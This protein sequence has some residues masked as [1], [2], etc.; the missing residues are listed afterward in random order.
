MNSVLLLIE[1]SGHNSERTINPYRGTI[2]MDTILSIFGILKGTIYVPTA[3]YHPDGFVPVKIT[4]PP[5]RRLIVFETTMAQYW[6]NI[7][8]KGDSAPLSNRNNFKPEY[9]RFSLFSDF[10]SL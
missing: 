6:I 5:L 9:E 7:T 1:V 3:T 2:P 10:P 4:L 8:S